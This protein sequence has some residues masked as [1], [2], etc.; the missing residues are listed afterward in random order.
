MNAVGRITPASARRARSGQIPLAETPAT[1][2][3]SARA[4]GRGEIRAPEVAGLRAES[5]VAALVHHAVRIGASD[6]FFSFNAN[7]VAVSVR[8]LGM[9]RLLSV[10]ATDHGHVVRVE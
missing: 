6:L 4:A 8:H 10:L 7:H 3:G 2:R 5:A 1:E 9:I